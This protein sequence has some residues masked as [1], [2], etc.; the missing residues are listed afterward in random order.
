MNSSFT[1]GREWGRTIV[2][3]LLGVAAFVVFLWALSRAPI[4]GVSALR[5][6]SVLFASLIGVVV[7]KERWSLPRLA[8]AMLIMMGI[9]VFATRA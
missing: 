5:E 3:G 9:V 1:I 7:L 2:S 8:G 6:T 4:G